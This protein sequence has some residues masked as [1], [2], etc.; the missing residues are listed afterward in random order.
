MFEELDFICE[1]ETHSAALNMAID[2]ALLENAARPLLR[3]YGWQRP[4][5]SF[6]YFGNYSEMA[7][8]AEE[9]DVVRR[10]TG[11]GTVLHGTDVTYSIVIPRSHPVYGQP[12]TVIYS[13][14]HTAICNVLRKLGDDVVLADGAGP[15][16]SDVCFANPV[17]ADVLVGGRKIAGAAQRR[18]RLGLLQQGSIQHENLPPEFPRQFAAALARVV[19]PA[20]VPPE[21]L[22]RAEALAGQKYSTLEWL[23]RR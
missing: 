2:E 22:Q 17:K 1:T 21:I 20:Q 4:S 13:A 7:L 5:L 18:T 8:F 16:I 15:R 12:A 10:W 19:H 23:G 14:I 6:G 9:R 11:G 3:L